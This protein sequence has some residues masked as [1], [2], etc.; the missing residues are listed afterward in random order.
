MASRTLY[1]WREPTLSRLLWPRSPWF[2]PLFFP[3]IPWAIRRR[4]QAGIEEFP[5]CQQMWREGSVDGDVLAVVLR[6]CGVLRQ[7]SSLAG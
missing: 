6:T 2:V 1:P 5:M 4:Q 3:L 7:W